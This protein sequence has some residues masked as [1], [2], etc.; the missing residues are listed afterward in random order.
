MPTNLSLKR[1]TASG[2]D[3]SRAVIRPHFL[4]LKGHGFSRAIQ[5]P[6]ILLMWTDRWPISQDPRRDTGAP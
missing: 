6:L 2:H 4:S 1:H 3:F 5:N